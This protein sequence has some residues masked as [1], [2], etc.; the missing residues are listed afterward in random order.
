[1]ARLSATDGAGITS[2][3]GTGAGVRV[4]SPVAAAVGTHGVRRLR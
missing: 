4:M 3:I 1:M 2:G